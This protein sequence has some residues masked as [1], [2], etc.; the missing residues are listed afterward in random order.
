[1]PK[2]TI[3]KAARLM[4]LHRLRAD[5]LLDDLTLQ[6]I[7]DAFGLNRSTVMRDLRDLDQV[8]E[9]YER[10]MKG[11][12]WV[13]R[14][15]SVNEFAE[16]ISATGDTV[17]AMVRDGLVEARKEGRRWRIPVG[18]VDRFQKGGN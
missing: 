4:I 15:L 17:R 3:S 1:M 7:G 11:Q 9:E 12:P 5:G 13:K 8:E 6:A 14:L 10:L 2:R 18:E 16:A